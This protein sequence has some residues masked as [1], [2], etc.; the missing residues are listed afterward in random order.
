MQ[1]WAVHKSHDFISF[2]CS[3]QSIVSLRKYAKLKSLTV[4]VS[5]NHISTSRAASAEYKGL[6]KSEYVTLLQ[7]IS[8]NI[9]MGAKQK[10]NQTT[11]ITLNI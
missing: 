9:L 11:F 5:Q 3:S 4:K 2:Y 7:S 1:E 10:Y 8:E 6:L